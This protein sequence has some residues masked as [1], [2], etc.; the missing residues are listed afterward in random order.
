M[1]DPNLL[2]FRGNQRET[3]GNQ[4]GGCI[5]VDQRR[6]GKMAR[7]GYAVIDQS[8]PREDYGPYSFNRNRRGLTDKSYD[9]AQF[10]PE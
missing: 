5:H 4:G 1:P 10:D 6:S 2:R 9:G 3:V 7:D 8:G